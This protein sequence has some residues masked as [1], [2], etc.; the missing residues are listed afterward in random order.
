MDTELEKKVKQTIDYLRTVAIEDI[1]LDQMDP[2]AHMM[3]VALLHEEQKIHDHIDS[4]PQMVMEHFCSHFVPYEKVEAVPA[5]ALLSPVFKPRKDMDV[6]TVGSGS[7]FSFKAPASHH[8]NNRSQAVTLNYIPIFSTTLIPHADIYVLSHDKLTYKQASLPV[9]MGSCNRVW[10]GITTK[11]EVECLQGMSVL[12][13]G[14]KGVLPERITVGADN[15]DL[16]MSTMREFDNIKMLEPFDA[17]Q[18]SNQF[19]SIVN[20][21]KE[22]LLNMED[23]A[24]FYITDKTI[25]RDL[26]KPKAYPRAFLQWLEDEVLDC[27]DPDTIW[28]QL[29]FPEK[30]FVPETLEVA[31]NILPVVNIDVN[32]LMLTQAAP[33][34]K[35]QKQEDSFFLRVI[36]T[37]TASQKQGFNASGKE[38]IIRD[39]DASCY[40]NGN[41]YRDVRN[42][43]NRFKDD[44][45]AFTEYN[46]IKDGEVLKR[47]KETIN[48]LGK[49]VGETNDKFRFDSGTYVMR[50][51]SLDTMPTTVKVSYMTTMGELG[52]IPQ[53]GD[54]MDNKNLPAIEQKVAIISSAMCGT[55]KA[56]AD[57]RYELLRY[58]SLTNDRLYTRMDID[59]FLRKEI[60]LEFGKEEFHRIF[61]RLSIQ[62]AGGDK[63]LRRGLYIDIEFKDKKNY[64]RAVQQSFDTLM[65]QR[66]ETLSCIAMPIIV[67]LRNLDVN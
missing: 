20:K 21:W 51:M 39:F 48:R 17:Q 47:L 36:E 62:G 16:E 66:I 32:S 52:N 46:G 25:D 19:F 53:A 42:L 63:S 24:L 54:M 5:I 55:D 9:N 8:T 27:F 28:L 31:I 60:M 6:V 35:L 14:T 45:Y 13:K 26:F 37:S 15:H 50:N 12:V 18:A 3:L 29:V 44:Y 61:I 43:Y 33:I 34:A 56:S 23:A 38:I 65:R 58:Y 40:Q 59:A 7:M 2:I 57:A 11:V 1:N 49:S 4:M 10:V 67:S 41:L 22:G 64:D 30:Y